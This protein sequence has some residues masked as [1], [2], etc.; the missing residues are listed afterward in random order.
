MSTSLEQSTVLEDIKELVELI[1][2]NLKDERWKDM[3]EN[4]ETLIEALEELAEY[5]RDENQPV[6]FG[7]N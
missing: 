4:A 5:Q 3:E 1:T 6:E 7:L 2:D